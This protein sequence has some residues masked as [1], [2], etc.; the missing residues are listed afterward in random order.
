M[1]NENHNALNAEDL[2]YVHMENKNQGVLNAKEWAF[3]YIK[4]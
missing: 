3:V 1:G 2:V 4:K